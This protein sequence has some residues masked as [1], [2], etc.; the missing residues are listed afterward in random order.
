M[1]NW[2]GSEEETGIVPT[3][4]MIIDHTD[5]DYILEDIDFIL[6]SYS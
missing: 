5:I 4:P 3:M 2:F 1:K 6:Y